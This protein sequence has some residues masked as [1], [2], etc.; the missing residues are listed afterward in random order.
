MLR[1]IFQL[2][3]NN[4]FYKYC[5]R[6]E[7]VLLLSSIVVGHVA[8]SQLGELI[9]ASL[10]TDQANFLSFDIYD[11]DLSKVMNDSN[12]NFVVLQ[13][14]TKFVIVVEYLDRF[15]TDKL[16]AVSLFFDVHINFSLCDFL[17][18]KTLANNYLR[19]SK[20]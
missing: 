6:S 17:A 12:L 3:N 11:I 19:H 14:M 9:S 15:L 13:T 1:V 10:N 16:I 8:H 2:K 18:F 4:F 7:D 5:D 20:Q